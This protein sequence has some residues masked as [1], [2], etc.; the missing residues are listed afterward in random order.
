MESKFKGKIIS[1]LRRLSWSWE[2]R[3]K[4]KQ[5]QKRDI[6]TFECEHCGV[7]VYEGSRNIEDTGIPER[8]PDKLVI[9]DK[10]YQDHIESVIPVEGFPNTV[11]SWDVYIERMFPEN[12]SDFDCLCFNCHEIKSW[13]EDELRKEYKIINKLE[14]SIDN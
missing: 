8:H 9:A 4:A 12:I 11:W 2:P 14:K 10:T 1:A 7:Y 5:L 13:L 3:N 6:A